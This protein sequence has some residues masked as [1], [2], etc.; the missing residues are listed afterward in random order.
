MAILALPDSTVRLLGSSISIRSPH[1]LVKELL[2]N[3]IDAKATIIDI[4]ISADTLENLTVRDNGH[5]IATQDFD[6]LG[7]RA[8]TSKL[9]SFG[10]LQQKGGSTLGFRGDALASANSVASVT[11]TT[12]TSHD[13]AAS[14]LQL[15]SFGGGVQLETPTSALVGTTVRAA[16]LFTYMPARRHY[17]SKEKQKTLSSIKRLL[18]SY[19]LARPYLRLS[20]RV[21]NDG[22]H[23]WSYSPGSTSGVK[24]AA[25]QIFGRKLTRNCIQ[26]TESSAEGGSAQS[27]GSASGCTGLTIDAFLPK[28]GCDL[29]AVR[30]KGAFVSVDHRPLSAAV[31]L[32]KKLVKILASLH[33]ESRDGPRTSRSRGGLFMQ[34]NVKCPPRSYDPNV[35][36][37]K[38]EVIFAD[39]GVILDCFESM[40]RKL[41]SRQEVIISGQVNVKGNASKQLPQEAVPLSPG[42]YSIEDE[43]TPFSDVPTK[44]GVVSDE[45][46]FELGESMQGSTDSIEGHGYECLRVRERDEMQVSMPI[47]NLDPDDVPKG[48]STETTTTGMKTAS[49]VLMARTESNVT[50]DFGIADNV[51]VVIPNRPARMDLAA[52]RPRAPVRKN[53]GILRYFPSKQGQ[54]FQIACD[55]TATAAA[56]PAAVNQ[57]SFETGARLPLQPLSESALNQMQEKLG[58]ESEAWLDEPQSAIPRQILPSHLFA[59]GPPVELNLPALGR[60]VG[61]ESLQESPRTRPAIHQGTLPHISSSPRVNV[62]NPF[63]TPPSARPLRGMMPSNRPRPVF[64]RHDLTMNQTHNRRIPSPAN[65]G[66][67]H[68]DPGRFNISTAS[69]AAVATATSPDPSSDDVLESIE[70]RGLTASSPAGRQVILPVRG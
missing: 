30:G 12:R 20:F 67:E 41:Y 31:G 66:V 57:V 59:L 58:A 29:D 28:P 36:P 56:A 70:G 63:P 52:E 21:N 8:H 6:S 2:D 50:D 3:A 25:L 32:P 55:E 16:Q 10:E 49:R 26:L 37:L 68:E 51:Q 13:L 40:C 33:A 17:L 34:V 1:D 43:M 7:R 53:N 69:N 64:E 46:T 47:T 22:T 54:D 45:P 38:D 11:I 4:S 23:S 39:E 18:Q 44:S 60:R 24:E 62:L 42:A 5:G 35:S 61:P 48:S 19:A 9:R 65:D 27:L 15:C 14:K